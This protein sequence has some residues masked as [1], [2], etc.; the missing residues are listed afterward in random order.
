ASF[1]TAN[2][3][4]TLRG[5]AADQRG[6]IS[7]LLN[8]S[9]SLGLITGA[10]LMGAI[11]AAASGALDVKSAQP[12]QLARGLH[13]TFA[14]ASVLIGM[15][16]AIAFRFYRLSSQPELRPAKAGAI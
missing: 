8:L 6:V 7:G 1:Q 13:T 14:V 12:E 15:A 5:I 2:N 9:R 10:S 4:A 16:L 11:F 3:T